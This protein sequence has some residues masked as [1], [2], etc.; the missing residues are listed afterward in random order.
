MV[1]KS[2]KS[3]IFPVLV[4]GVLPLLCIGVFKLVYDKGYAEGKSKAD[5]ACQANISRIYAEAESARLKSVEKARQA[6][7][8]Y[9]DQRAVR[10]GKE[11]VRY[12]QVQK[13]VERPV[14]R[15]TCLDDDGLSIING[16]ASGSQE[17]T[18]TK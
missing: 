7:A 13:I 18:A 17:R 1:L 11:R 5:A 12:V 3:W 6:S 9:Q 10:K 4:G 16:S 2:I 8:E 15:N 14:Y